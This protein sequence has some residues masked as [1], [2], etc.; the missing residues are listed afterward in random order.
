MSILSLSKSLNSHS[1]TLF[2]NFYRC[3]C[4]TRPSA[5]ARLK[6]RR[7]LLDRDFNRLGSCSLVRGLDSVDLCR[8]RLQ[9]I[10]SSAASFASDGGGFGGIHGN[11][12]GRGGGGDGAAE[13]GES[14][15]RSV[16]VGAGEASAS[17]SDVIILDV[18]VSHLRLFFLSFSLGLKVLFSDFI[19]KE[20]F[21]LTANPKITREMTFFFLNVRNYTLYIL[22]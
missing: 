3:F 14:K 13:G 20:L 6:L 12:G 15:P 4:T 21:F 17:S 8:S 11:G 5:L 9:C 2:T 22:C 19:L 7:C 1:T 16:V 18:G 10:G